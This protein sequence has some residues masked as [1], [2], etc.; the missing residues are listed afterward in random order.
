MRELAAAARPSCGL[1][2]FNRDGPSD[3]PALTVTPASGQQG[4]ISDDLIEVLAPDHDVEVTGWVDGSWVALSKELKWTCLR[5]TPCALTRA[6]QTSGSRAASGFV[7]PGAPGGAEN[8]GLDLLQNGFEG[9]RAAAGA[10]RTWV[11]A[12][13]AI[14][15]AP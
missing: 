15:E 7:R 12:S 1:R 13:Q 11:G 9:C 5:P 2:A 6:R 4:T 3:P 14:A 10:M 8:P